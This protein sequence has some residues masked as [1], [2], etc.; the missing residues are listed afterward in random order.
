MS[1]EIKHV[2]YPDHPNR[3]SARIGGP[4][5]GQCK[6]F[7]TPNGTSCVMHGGKLHEVKIA[8]ESLGLYRVG[9]FNKRLNELK[10]HVGVRSLE[11][12]L[13]IMRMIL[14][15][16]LIKCD[17]TQELLL[18]ST[19]IGEVIADI[20][21]LVISS[22]KLSSRTGMLVGRTEAV[23]LA[24]K[25]VEIMARHVKDETILGR[26]ADEIIEVFVTPNLEESGKNG[27]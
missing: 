6:N 25:V 7:A 8:T 12:E 10:T 5:E 18:Y 13:A 23:V 24:G 27:R 11:D 1:D 19:R 9:R 22:E 21:N 4:H 2:P 3:C 17:T 20:R 14:E 16:I 15:E 26:I